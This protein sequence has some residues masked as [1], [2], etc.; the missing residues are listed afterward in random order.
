MAIVSS[1]SGPVTTTGR[2][3]IPSV[4]RIATCGWL[5]IGSVMYVPNGPGF[6]IVN[7]PPSTS[8]GTSF[9]VRARVGE[10]VHLAR[11]QPQ[12]LAVGVADH[13]RDQALE[14]EVDRDREVD[15]VVDD[16]RVVADARVHLRE[17]V[18][19]CRRTRAR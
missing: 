14:V 17:V 4:D 1:P 10:V 6:V 11:D 2:F 18:A 3:L 15:V 7:V 5:M 12:A 8:S 19:P 16:Q 9:F 13:R